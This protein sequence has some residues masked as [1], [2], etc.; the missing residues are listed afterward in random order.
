MKKIKICFFVFLFVTVFLSFGVVSALNYSGSAISF[1]QKSYTGKFVMNGGQVTLTLNLMQHPNQQVT[2]IL[3]SSNGTVFQVNGTLEEGGVVTGSCKDGGSSVFFEAYLDEDEMSFSLI[4]PGANG[5]P[6]YDKAQYLVF[7]RAASGNQANVM[8]PTPA[9]TSTATMMQ[10]ANSPA[11][12]YQSNQVQPQN[13]PYTSQRVSPGGQG[14]QV[15]A[16]SNSGP[17]EVGDKS[18]GFKFVPPSGWVHQKNASGILLGHNTIAGMI[19]VLPH[20]SKNMQ[21]MQQEMNKGIQ[22]EGTSLRPSGNMSPLNNNTLVSNYTGMANGQ[23]VRAKGFGVLSPYGGGAYI[24]AVSTPDKFGNDLVSAAKTVVKNMRYSKVSSSASG[25]NQFFADIWITTTTSTSSAV[26]LYPDGTYSDHYEASYSGNFEDGGGN[27]T[28][29]WGAGGQQNQRGR[30]S[31]RGNKDQGQII[32]HPAS[33][34]EYVYNY[35]V[36]IENGQKYYSE[37]YFNGTLY[38]RK[39]KYD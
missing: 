3:K 31:V 36:H 20:T 23:Q 30:W 10:K 11:N 37:Y 18:W 25:L 8:A 6:D 33:G 27:N 9:R 35:K 39:N 13:N 24:I 26:Y 32:I 29:N 5:Q 19:V 16:N 2:G 22:E 38:H 12:Q 7:N 34:E 28:G 21:Q 4:E 1:Q 15:A 17:N 14:G